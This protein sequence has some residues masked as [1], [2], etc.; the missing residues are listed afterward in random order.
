VGEVCRKKG[1]TVV[2]PSL[3][4]KRPKK[5]HGQK[6]PTE[7]TWHRNIKISTQRGFKTVLDRL[8]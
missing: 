7:Q 2:G 5:G 6:L 4:R 3:G 1:P 8:M